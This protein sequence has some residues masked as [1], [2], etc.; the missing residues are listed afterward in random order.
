MSDQIQ[1][2]NELMRLSKSLAEASNEYTTLCQRAA[3]A[4][5]EYDIAKAKAM[6][7][8]DSKAKVD[9]MKAEVTLICESQM[10]D[11]HIAEAQREAMKE[12][13]RALQ[14]VLNAIQTRAAF[15]RAELNLAGRYN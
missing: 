15:L 1:I 14:S 3:E 5:D 6:I 11:A 12:R 8:A 7:R 10:R 4:R 9:V 13:L 2:D